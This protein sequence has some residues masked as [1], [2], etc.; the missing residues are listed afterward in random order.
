MSILLA[1][2]F[3]TLGFATTN[4]ELAFDGATTAYRADFQT[5]NGR[6]APQPYGYFFEK[7]EGEILSTV[8]FPENSKMTA[9]VYGCHEHQPGEFDCHKENKLE[10]GEYARSTNL[11]SAEEMKKSLPLAL[12]FFTKNVAPEE[13][14][15]TVKLWEAFSNI[16]FVINYKKGNARVQY[17]LAC[18]YHG[19]EM[20]CHFKRDAGPGQPMLP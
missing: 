8:F 19:T 15:L 11:Y 1:I 12:D 20:D 3:S 18:H 10:I 14:I 6:P 16:R 5:E 2:A 13:T 17:F 4:L 7:E 9:S